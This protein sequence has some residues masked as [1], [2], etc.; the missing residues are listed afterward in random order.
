MGEPIISA[1]RDDSPYSAISYYN[2]ETADTGKRRNTELWH[3]PHSLDENKPLCG[4]SLSGRFK[5]TKGYANCSSCWANASLQR[6]DS[7]YFGVLAAMSL[8]MPVPAYESKWMDHN[9]L[10]EGD[11]VANKGGQMILTPRGKIVAA[12][13][14]DPVGWWDSTTR[15]FHARRPVELA[16]VCGLPL[17]QRQ[18]I[19][20]I[21]GELREKAKKHGRHIVTCVKCA[22]NVE[23][24]VD[25]D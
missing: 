2:K 23:P 19:V 4:A 5:R 14:R 25:V 22:I 10:Y 12:D 18:L 1:E 7:R 20:S 13:V 11:L 24:R 8:G 17:G 9:E 15:L 3:I 16:T 6:I 21:L